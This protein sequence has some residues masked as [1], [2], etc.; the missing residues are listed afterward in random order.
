MLTVIRATLFKD[1]FA[2]RLPRSVLPASLCLVPILLAVCLAWGEGASC[3]AQ[4]PPANA[5]R[6]RGMPND[7]SVTDHAVTMDS[8]VELCSGPRLPMTLD[9]C[10]A[11]VM[12]RNVNIHVAYLGRVLQKFDLVTNRDYTFVPDLAL[13]AAAGRTSSEGVTST[14]TDNMGYSDDSYNRTRTLSDTDTWSV[15]PGL[16]G[17]APTGGRYTV[18]WALKGTDAF[19]ETRTDT[20]DTH[21]GWNPTRR[22]GLEKVLSLSLTQPLLKGAGIDYNTVAVKQAKITE[23]SNVLNLKSSIISEITST[24]QAYRDLLSQKWSVDISANSLKQAKAN[25]ELAQVKIDIGRMAALDIVQYEADVA[26]RE[27]SLAQALN[28][29]NTSRLT[30]LQ[31]LDMDRG[32]C[33]EPS[34]TIDFDPVKLDDE[35]LKELVFE[36]KPAYLSSLLAIKSSELTLLQ[37]KRDQL[38]DLSLGAGATVTDPVGETDTNISETKTSGQDINWNVGLT[39]NVPIF[40]PAER[41]VRRQLLS[42]RSSLHVQRIQLRKQEEDILNE[43]EQRLSNIRLLERQVELSHRSRVLADKKVEVEM[44]K[45]SKGRSSTFQLVTF[46]T[47]QFEAQQSELSARISYLNALSGLDSYLGT[48][49]DTWNIEFKA[50]RQETEDEIAK[51]RLDDGSGQD[52]QTRPGRSGEVSP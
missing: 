11:L 7:I 20:G 4:E 34:E 38:W 15:T 24:V 2:T 22:S 41:A 6:T 9:E 40:G 23:K 47:Q 32:T 5:T 30:L 8:G 16:G 44:V 43:L 45:L 13:D 48:T 3:L 14:R 26:S 27:L 46:Q 21:G 39:L 31:L 49:M 19:T 29:Y 10:L 28:S 52:Q 25:L 1:F 36:T 50:Y 42:A 51:A 35:T 37:A 33:V 17:L 12:R 18:S